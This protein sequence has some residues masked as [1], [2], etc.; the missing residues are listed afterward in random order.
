MSELTKRW[1]AEYLPVITRR[2]KW[3]KET[4]PIEINDIVIV[5]EPNEIR[6]S[7]HLGRVVKIYPGPDGVTRIADV[8]LAN[9]AVKAKRSIGRLAVLDLKSSN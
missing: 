5:I 2:S 3:F 8:K 6:C 7:W 4:K 9:G 1:Y